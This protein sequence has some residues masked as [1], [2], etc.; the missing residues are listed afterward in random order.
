MIL[1]TSKENPNFL[2]VDLAIWV[3]RSIQNKPEEWI[4]EA[5]NY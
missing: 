1:L 5:L 3:I 2:D 4:F